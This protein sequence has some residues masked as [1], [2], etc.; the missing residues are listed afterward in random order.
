MSGGLIQLVSSGNQDVALTYNPEITFFKKKYRRHTN[1]SIELKEIPAE[2]Q[3]SYG[4]KISFNLPTNGDLIYRCFVEVQIPTLNFSDSIIKNNNYI[5]WKNNYISRLLNNVNKWNNLYS[6]LKNYASIELILYQQLSTLFLSDNLILDNIKE[7]VIRF[8][9]I[10]KN[11]INSY[12]IL[13]DNDL[14]NKINMSGY[15][16]SIN[17]L[18][19]YDLT[20]MN[21]N[22]ISITII[23]KNLNQMYNTIIEYLTYYHSNWKEN[24]QIYNSFIDNSSNINFAWC[25][26]LGH[27]YFSKFE[28]DIGGQLV[29]QYSSDQFNIY[30]NHHLQE[31]QIN[32]YYIMIG[33]NPSLYTFNSNQK[34]STLLIIPLIFFFNKNPGSSLPIV[35]MRNTTSTI[36]LTINN[37]KNLIYFRDWETE[38]N[39]L[40]ILKVSFTGVIDNLLNFSSYKYDVDSKQITYNLINLNYRSLELIYVQLNKNDI[41]LILTFGSNNIILLND[42]IYFKN[43]LF[44]LPELQNKLGGYDSYIDYNY[45]LNLIPKPNIKLLVE[46]IF[47]DDIER[48]KLT[49]S[50]LEYVIEGFQ[51]NIFDVNN[52]ILFDG[53][54]SIDKPNK[55][56][57]WFIQ[58]KNFLNGLSEYGKVTPYLYDYSNYYKNKIF[59]QQIITL[60]Q[61]NIINTQIVDSFYEIVQSYQTLNRILPKGVYYY[62]F[63]LY[64]E[65]LQPSGSVNL[66][67]I[68]EKK[69]RYEMNQ[70]FLTEYFSS[71]INPTNVGLQAKILSVSYNFFVVQNGLG[72]L[73]FTLS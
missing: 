51:E 33:H 52:L 27:Y 40:L 58:P 57:K 9:N 66:S 55:Y 11:Q 49:S 45:L 53:E 5:L 48:K 69:F 23:Q 28:L 13:I 72:R 62:S 61:L 42:W 38:Y 30:Q 35:A 18:L 44:N 19:T 16:L 39:N 20:V 63:S 65:E 59:N 8:N 3:S 46:Y 10:Y 6:N 17:Q 26:Y 41:N 1:F 71:K 25:Q 47:L 54:I 34:K 64:P 31:E 60:N 37:L 22:Y 43:N 67:V 12:V 2:Q 21:S 70:N 68:K 15:L 7:T 73:I 4:D 56:F 24:L 50:K 14:Y 32:N 29:E 36:T